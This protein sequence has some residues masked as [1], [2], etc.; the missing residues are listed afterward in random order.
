MPP[1][2]LFERMGEAQHAHARRTDPK[3]SHDAAAAVTPDLPDL[4][5]L[6]ER[7][8]L[9]RPEGFLDIELVRWREDLGP[10]TLRTRRAELGARNII[11]DSGRRRT[12][13]GAKSPHTIWI[14]RSFVPDAPEIRDPPERASDKDRR[15]GLDMALELESG[16]KQ[17]RSEGRALW[18]DQLYEAARLMR[19][20]AS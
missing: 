9:G 19:L 18:S 6:V 15:A 8:A 12:P 7:F 17:M 20:L 1:E 14:H 10:S 5:A 2:S 13:H 4:Q 11:L 16:A 3:T